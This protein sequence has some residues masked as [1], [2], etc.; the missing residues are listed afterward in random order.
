MQ[1]YTEETNCLDCK[2][3][4]KCF[5]RLIPTE[6]EFINRNK[7]QISY[8]KGENICKQ[9]AYASYISYISYGLVKLFLECPDN[10]NINLRIIKT[11]EFIGLSSIYGD[12]IYNYSAKALSDSSVCLI[13]KAGFKKLLINNGKFASEIIKL[14]CLYEKHLFDTIKSIGH[15]QMNGRLADSLLYLSSKEFK[16]YNVFNYIT[17]KDIAEFS[18]ISLESAVRLLTEFKNEEILRIEGKNIEI[19]DLGRLKEISRIG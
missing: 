3:S 18:G 12:N 17:R 11:S 7:I 1:D 15:K 16:D 6:L 4:A 9:S 14:Y 2:K 13:D 10:K 8:R 5:Q 19:I